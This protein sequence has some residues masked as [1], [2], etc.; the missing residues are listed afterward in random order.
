MTLQNSNSSVSFLPSHILLP[1]FQN[2]TDCYRV[3]RALKTT[4]HEI[5]KLSLQ[6]MMKILILFKV[7]KLQS[8]II[9]CNSAIQD[10]SAEKDLLDA[11]VGI[12]R[13][14]FIGMFVLEK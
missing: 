11:K 14:S 10:L 6:T 8:D 1:C 4:K 3:L 9:Q 5:L 7:A 12:R 13:L 2:I